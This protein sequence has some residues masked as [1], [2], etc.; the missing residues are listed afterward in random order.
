[1]AVDSPGQLPGFCLI[2]PSSWTCR[3]FSAQRTSAKGF[4]A[5]DE[6]PPAAAAYSRPY[7]D[8]Q[9]LLLEV[10]LGTLTTVD[11]R[12]FLPTES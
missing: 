3:Y 4:P 6:S 10:L 5:Q 12:P 9:W 2:V 8:A 1:M 11:M 7:T